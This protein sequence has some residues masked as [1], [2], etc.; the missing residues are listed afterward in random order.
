MASQL[1]VDLARFDLDSPD[2]RERVAQLV[3]RAKGIVFPRG[4]V[5]RGRSGAA[6]AISDDGGRATK[7]REGTTAAMAASP[8]ARKRPA[9]QSRHSGLPSSLLATKRLPGKQF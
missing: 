9:S 1:A 4:R 8:K 7:G 2:L 3:E 5:T 6:A